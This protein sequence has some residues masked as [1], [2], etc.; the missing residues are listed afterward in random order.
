MSRVF[1]LQRVV[2]LR[3]EGVLNQPLTTTE[4]SYSGLFQHWLLIVPDSLSFEDR[5]LRERFK[6][7]G[8]YSSADVSAPSVLLRRDLPP[9]CPLQPLPEVPLL[10][11]SAPVTC[12]SR[13]LSGGAGA[14]SLPRL[15]LGCPPATLP[16]YSF[17]WLLWRVGGWLVF[18]PGPRPLLPITFIPRP[19]PPASPAPPPPR[20]LSHT[21]PCRPRA[22][23]SPPRRGGRCQGSPP[24]PPP[25]PSP[26]AWRRPALALARRPVILGI[27]CNKCRSASL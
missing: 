27:V 2:W 25:A 20:S 17:L 16:T 26:R 4:N 8:L 23:R 1:F 24:P 15:S 7:S 18:S 12:V 3:S 9:D 13:P 6:D 14:P 5:Y 22:A 10:Q 19:P 21:C 11:H